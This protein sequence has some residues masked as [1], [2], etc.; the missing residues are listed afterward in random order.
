MIAKA[1]KRSVEY[2]T[3]VIKRSSV[4][5][6]V[7]LSRRSTAATAGLLLRSRTS[8]RYRSIAD[9]A[10]LHAGLVNHGPTA[11]R[12]NMMLVLCLCRQKIHEV[13]SM[14]YEK[15]TPPPP[16]SY[17]SVSASQVAADTSG[18]DPY[19]AGASAQTPYASRHQYPSQYPAPGQPY[20][21]PT[22]AY[23]SPHVYATPQYG[24]AHQQ[25]VVVVSGS[26]N[27]QPLQVQAVQS[28]VGHIVFACLVL[29][30]CN[31]L[32]GLIAFILAGR[33]AVL[34]PYCNFIRRILY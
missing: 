12:S 13:G 24:G 7:C 9:A 25:H 16:P 33:Y 28:F 29:W 27:Q 14:D 23:P 30:C 4:R 20:V 1:T 18:A 22:T 17:S 3:S 11:R 21:Y 15:A 8:S 2:A 19:A 31:W 26:A 6:S 32:F 10:A 5:P 34:R